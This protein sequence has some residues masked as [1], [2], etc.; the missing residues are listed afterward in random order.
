M[1]TPRLTPYRARRA[2]EPPN[3]RSGGNASTLVARCADPGVFHHHGSAPNCGAL[4]RARFAYLPKPSTD[5]TRAV[6]FPALKLRFND[7]ELRHHS[8]LGRNAPDDTR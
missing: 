5:F 1:I 3:Q 2:G 6:V 4:P 7:V 8:F